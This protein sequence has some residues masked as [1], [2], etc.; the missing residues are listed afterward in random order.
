MA[1]TRPFAYNTGSTIDGTTQIGNI[2]IGDSDQDYSQ[3]PGGVKWWMGPDE[4]LGYV[5]AHEV[6]TG[7]Q[8]TPVEVDAS[9]AFWRSTSLTDQSFLDLLN[10]LP[11]T[12]G[13]PLFTNV[14]DALS[15]LTTNEYWTSYSSFG[16]SGFQWMTVTSV[17]PTTASGIGQNN[18]TAAITQSGG[19]MDITQGVFNPTAFP[20]Q[21]G[22]PFTGNQILNQNS[23]TFTAT[24]SQPVTDAL[25]AFSS[26]G[27][28]SLY[29]PIQV[30]APF[31]P[32]FGTSVSYQN[33]VNGTQYTEL[34]GNEG[35]AIIRIDGTVS[36]VTFVYTASEYYCNVCFGFV[37]QN[38]L[39]TPTPTPTTGAATSTPTPTSILATN[40][41]TPTPTYYYYYLLNCDL[42]TNAYG[43]SLDPHIHLS[44]FTFNVDTNMCYT[45]IGQDPNPYYDYDLDISTSVT[46][47]T[48]VL[49]GIGTPTPTP[50]PVPTDTPTATPT[51]TTTTGAVTSTPTPTPTTG[52]ATSTPTPTID[53]SA[54]TTYTISGCSSSNVIVA[55]LGP[56]NFFPGDTFFLDFTGSTAS[57]CYTIV[58]K[59]DTAPD[60]GSNPISSYSNCADCIDGTT[61]TYTI[62]GCTNLNVLVADLGP[63]A[64][65]AGDVFNITFTGATPSGCYKIINKIVDTPT[66]TGSPLTFYTTCQLCEAALPTATPTPLPA[67]STPVP[68][69]NTPTP[70]PTSTPTPTPTTVGSCSGIPYVLSN[71]LTPPS[72]GNTMW[73]SNGA[74][75]T[76]SNL[77]NTLAVSNP[78]YFHKIDN[79]GTDRTSYFNNFTGSTFSLTVCQ[80]GN[81]A[82][83]SGI[84]GAITYDNGLNS[85]MLDATKLSLV[86]SSPV[87]AFTYNELVYVS[88][89]SA[90]QP[91]TTPI[92]TGV[93]TSTPATATPAPTDTP[94]PATSTPTPE[95]ATATPTPTVAST[96]TPTPLPATSTP[97]ATP[98]SSG[99][100]SWYFYSDEGPMN[101]GA[102]SANGNALFW[103]QTSNTETYNPNYTGGTFQIYLA[104]NDS[105][106][107]SY[108]TQFSGL[109][110]GGTIT[111]SQNGDTAIYTLTSGQAVLGGPPGNQFFVMN[112]NSSGI[113]TKTSN[114]PFVSGTT[115]SVIF[116]AGGTP[117]P[118]PT[119]GGP[120]ATPT[121][122]TAPTST[123]TPT[124]APTSTP[125]PLPA[126]ATPT[127]SATA[128]NT[129]TPAP[130]TATPTVTPIPSNIIVAAGG[131]NVL[132][133][134]YDGGDNWTNSS[135]G[136]TFITQPAYAVATDGNMFVA[137]G[138]A[139][140]GNSNY[141]LWSYDGDTWSGSTNG[142]TMF[143]SQVRG[144]GYGGDK[145]VAVGISSGAAKIAY[146]YDGKTWS[147]A[148]NS[149]VFGST[150]LSVAYNG[151]RWV[152]TAAKGGGNTNTIAYS[153]DGIT[154]SGA[155]NSW[156]IFSGSC[157]N[158]AW[159]TD[160]W[161]AVGTGVNRMAYSTDGVTWTG[162]TSGNSRITG[163][164]YGISHNGSQWVAAGQGTNSLSYSSDGITWSGSTNGNTIFS[165][166]SA[167]VTWAG[168]KW[169]AGGLG[170]PN[171]LATSTDGDTWS[172]TTNGNT[173]MNN[174]V[175]SLAAKY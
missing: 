119:P 168:T 153:D 94:T 22:V 43:R 91:T 103:N 52:A 98:T 106:G 87:S 51:P 156:T 27:N 16:S 117:T 95:P 96:S 40:T 24:F 142:N 33:P 93:P 13:L 123:P 145:W 163:V 64:F 39:P 88:V 157:N 17:T 92:P 47:C 100:G 167:S 97:T 71:S 18:I 130:P 159:G 8:P 84:T 73:V 62:S 55:D 101:A 131:V 114:A 126:T 41:P 23:G 35:Y 53:L 77:V 60:D 4:D 107:T 30:S 36:S 118:T 42:V 121:P 14:T 154:W 5:I 102:P 148:T 175:L 81:S 139:G 172:A 19:G 46:D 135:N 74:P 59:I 48:D 124:S 141:L 9:L 75:P 122:T 158:V 111:L 132:S 112:I 79:D 32:I 134:S 21:Y 150:P 65:F 136:N 170:G 105:T 113:Q 3:D 45:I 54:V 152:A 11:I 1:T 66:D 6:P 140:G 49:C 90:N 25:V 109:T 85:F 82:I 10:V 80:N 72:S 174:R 125:T 63:G 69:T 67:T 2:A 161:V 120:T 86:Q 149:N 116:G 166:M 162:S 57:E 38:N 137:G 50:T 70:T 155:T 7:D 99:V 115:I 20:E 138:T 110:T 68:S 15:W 171:Q 31:T 133:Y 127:P 56:G 61:T 128:T 151:S 146:S 89:T 34:T 104:P 26:I 78:A 173:I 169:I 160:K 147:G 83:Y 28:N 12:R 76:A 129:P 164:G 29:V 143:N 165:L 37:N 58:N 44:G 144:I 108:A